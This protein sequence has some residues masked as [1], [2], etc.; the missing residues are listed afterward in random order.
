[1]LDKTLVSECVE[2]EEYL[3]AGLVLLFTRKGIFQAR[4]YTGDTEH[5]YLYRSLKQ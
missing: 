4:I 2:H 1:M 3:E 5:R